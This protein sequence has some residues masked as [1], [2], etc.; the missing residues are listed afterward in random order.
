M[1][2]VFEYHIE[3]VIDGVHYSGHL[4]IGE[5][6]IGFNL[7]FKPSILQFANVEPPTE[8][9]ELKQQI[10]ISLSR[11]NVDLELTEDEYLLFLGL[12]VIPITKYYRDRRFH[13]LNKK[14]IDQ[15]LPMA[16][17]PN[18]P[19]QTGIITKVAYDIPLIVR[20]ML[21]SPKFGCALPTA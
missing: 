3:Q 11:T 12:L 6:V 19:N 9:S 4:K 13:E 15:T 20:H 21:N 2:T 1:R 10:D 18:V 5:A 17:D 16:H 8:V 7:R 14:E